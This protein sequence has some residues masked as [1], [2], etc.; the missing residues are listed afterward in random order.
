MEGTHEAPQATGIDGYNG[1][2][3]DLKTEDLTG[4]CASVPLL[5]GA[6]YSFAY[7][8]E[9]FKEVTVGVACYIQYCT[10]KTTGGPS[11]SFSFE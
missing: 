11:A 5:T 2:C 10:W 4:G 8:S 9:N 6:I 3:T 7:Y 1:E